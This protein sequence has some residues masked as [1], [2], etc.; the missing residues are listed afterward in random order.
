LSFKDNF[1]TVLYND[2]ISILCDDVI[3]FLGLFH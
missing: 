1:E 2:R 3:K